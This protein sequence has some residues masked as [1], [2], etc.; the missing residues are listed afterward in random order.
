MIKIITDKKKIEEC[1]HCGKEI[2]ERYNHLGYCPK[3]YKDI[4]LEKDDK[5]QVR[6]HVL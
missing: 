4:R 1:P 5:R 3:C 2:T 6:F